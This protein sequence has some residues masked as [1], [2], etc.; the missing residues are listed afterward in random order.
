MVPFQRALTSDVRP[1]LLVLLGAVAFV[2]LIACAN[3]ASLLLARSVT[4]QRELSL[5]TAL[6]AGRSRLL[7]QLVTENL[8]LAGIGGATGVLV[9]S[10]GVRGLAALA[11]AA[12][13]RVD[14][15]AVDARVLVFTALVTVVTSVACGLL[16]AWRS[17]GERRERPLTIGPAARRHRA[18]ARSLL[19]VADSTLALVLLAG[20]G[21]ML[22]TVVA[23]T[24]VNPGFRSDA[25][26]VAPV[27]AHRDAPIED[28]AECVVFQER[29]VERCARCRRRGRAAWP[30]RFLRRRW[31]TAGP[32]M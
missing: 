18:R 21:L 6:G 23:L 30:D 19:V 25:I 26:L 16:P 8:L 5:R 13:P 24:R 27:R 14:H 28:E 2:L 10:M 1:T 15:A 3:V 29:V 32:C 4:R 17:S 7:R 9:A 12:L 20:A 22:R 11:P 31:T